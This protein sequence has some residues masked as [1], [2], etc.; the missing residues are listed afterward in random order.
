MTISKSDLAV[1]VKEAI[2]CTKAE[3]EVAVDEMFVGIRTGL[4]A[5][6]EVRIHQ[7]GTF[8]APIKEAYTGRNPYNGESI[9]VPAKRHIRFKPGKPLKQAVA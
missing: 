1:I 7:F 9:D 6:E 4:A 5:G 8:L 3:S 2:G